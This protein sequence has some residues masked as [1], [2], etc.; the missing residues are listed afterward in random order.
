MKQLLFFFCVLIFSVKILNADES[1][2]KTQSPSVLNNA[3]NITAFYMG[4]FSATHVLKKALDKSR[5]KNKKQKK[6]QSSLEKVLAKSSSMFRAPLVSAIK[7]IKLPIEY[8]VQDLKTNV[9]IFSAQSPEEKRN[10]RLMKYMRSF[11]R[12]ST[13]INACRPAVLGF[14]VPLLVM[15]CYQKLSQ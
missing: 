15:N 14:G 10:L 5:K 8:L 2:K 7:T 6:I 13:I 11:E 9:Q 3:A 1:Q 4:A 12:T